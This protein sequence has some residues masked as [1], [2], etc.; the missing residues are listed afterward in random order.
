M[1]QGRPSP[2]FSYTV[3]CDAVASLLFGIFRPSI[4]VWSPSREIISTIASLGSVRWGFPVG[5]VALL[6][7]VTSSAANFGG[8]S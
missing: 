2:G 1:H 6:K 7:A 8:K 5:L 3:S 4:F